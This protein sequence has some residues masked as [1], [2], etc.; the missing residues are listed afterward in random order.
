MKCISPLYVR[1]NVVPCGK[2]NFC[3]QLRALDWMF[4]LSNEMEYAD[5]AHF[6]TLTLR[7]A[8]QMGVYKRH[9]QLFFKRLR[10]IQGKRKG[11][12]K[13]VY[14]A[15][16]E[17]GS[18]T[19]R[20]HYHAIIFNC[21]PLDVVSSWKLGRVHV[22][23]VTPASIA[24][25]TGYSMKSGDYPKGMRKPF[26]LMSRRPAIGMKYLETHG[27]WHRGNGISVD[28]FR[29]YTML[30]GVRG[31]LPRFYRDKIFKKFEREAMNE[32][33]LV[34]M[35]KAFDKQIKYLSQF[36]PNPYDYLL[37]IQEQKNKR[38]KLKF[39]INETI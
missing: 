33:N 32:I 4:R 1:S 20:P 25:V 17:Y 36:H 9:L 12:K 31:H 24:Y 18:K 26:S 22:G 2:C 7:F 39:S 3:R 6:V 37:Q 11:A 21:Q 29:S 16:A 35:D 8:P 19:L 15:V 5:S 27:S 30:K 38:L 10:K 28:T 14:Y 13:V 34:L 23:K